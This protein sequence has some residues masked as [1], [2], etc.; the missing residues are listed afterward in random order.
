M[1]FIDPFQAGAIAP[2]VICIGEALVDRLGPLGGDPAF[3][4]PVEDCFGG[5]PANVACGLARLG[6][7]VGLVSR[8]GDDS[9]GRCFQKLLEKR[10]VNLSGL[11][12]DGV[13]P[14]RIV[15]V[16]REL[17]GERFFQGFSGDRGQGFSDQALELKLLQKS[18]PYLSKK[19]RWLI[20]GSIPL[21]TKTSSATLLWSV[22][23]AYK[24]GI[25]IAFDINWRPK[26]WNIDH[27]SDSAPDPGEI[28]SI[29]SVLEY[30]AL[31][32]LSKEEAI[33]FF[34]SEDPY[35]ISKAIISHPNVLITD[36]A[37]LI[38]WCID[39]EKGEIK[40]L[41]PSHVVD[42]TGAG[43]AFL[44]GILHCF[45]NQD[46]LTEKS[47]N[48]HEK[49]LFAAGCGAIVCGG[50]G[51]INPQPTQNEVEVFLSQ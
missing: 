36:G 17:N 32:K 12:F 35:E 34:D 13:R 9:T 24:S 44:A 45:L 4:Q 1:T 19:A 33:L 31:I 43:D 27:A 3:D 40:A 8:L 2:D 26:F 48:F 39:D 51:A 16:K 28:T 25:K 20:V 38:R 49:I 22:K 41:S 30:C 37:G 21:A 50:S 23:S 5:A 42:T 11:Q 7:K 15:L 18:W 10:G 46:E 14:T 29:I 47:L 6:R